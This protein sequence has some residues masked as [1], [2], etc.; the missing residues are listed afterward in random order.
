MTIL[1]FKE[2]LN[3]IIK[4]N[5]ETK[6][7]FFD[8]LRKNYYRQIGKHSLPT[9][10][11]MKYISENNNFNTYFFMEAFNSKYYFLDK[12]PNSVYRKA[13][14]FLPLKKANNLFNFRLYDFRA[15]VH[16]Y[17]IFESINI[18]FVEFVTN[19]LVTLL[20]LL[21]KF[22]FFLSFYFL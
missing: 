16:K 19:C 12:V 2:K 21:I 13:W 22:F 1:N 7:Y 20:T 10:L 4:L 9:N 3:K 11:S 8:I 14:Y 5:L 17:N 6:L 15:L 18:S